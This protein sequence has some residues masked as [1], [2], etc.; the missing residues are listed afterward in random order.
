MYAQDTVWQI[1]INREWH[2][3]TY[4]MA[5][6][7]SNNYS[8]I[9]KLCFTVWSSWLGLCLVGAIFILGFRDLCMDLFILG[10]GTRDLEQ[11]LGT[12]IVTLGI[13]KYSFRNLEPWNSPSGGSCLYLWAFKL[14]YCV[15]FV[16]VLGIYCMHLN[17][18]LTDTIPKFPYYMWV[19]THWTD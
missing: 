9:S 6:H 15:H 10:L 4:G 2:G 5:W 3:V 14:K 13:V 17:H 7:S 1:E 11:I 16:P 12:L 18:I 8:S 19:H